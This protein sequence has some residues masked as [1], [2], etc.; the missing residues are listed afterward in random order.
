MER[1]SGDHWAASAPVA[2]LVSLRGWLRSPVVES[3]SASQICWPYS[4]LDRKSTERPS[5][6]NWRP[7]SPGLA[8]VVG[9][10]VPDAS[11]AWR[12]SCVVFAF[13]LRLTEVTS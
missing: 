6:A 13:C 4:R 5:G 11:M 12:K 10:F 3:K 8:T 7:E 9:G 1:P 2:R